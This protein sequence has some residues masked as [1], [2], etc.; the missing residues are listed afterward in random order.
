METTS[1]EIYLKSGHMLT[2][3]VGAFKTTKDHVS[4]RITGMEWTT[5]DGVE[6]RLRSVDLDEIVAIVEVRG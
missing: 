1:M 6:R 5:P 4:Q 2:V 3:Q